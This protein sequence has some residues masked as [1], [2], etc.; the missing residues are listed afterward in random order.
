ME[1]N[2][3]NAADGFSQS[4]ENT[5][6][7]FLNM[8]RITCDVTADTIPT[9]APTRRPTRRPTQRPTP[10]PVVAP[11]RVPT[12]RPTR[13]P[14]R[15]PTPSPDDSNCVLYQDRSLEPVCLEAGNDGKYAC[16]EASDLLDARATNAC[17][18]PMPRTRILRCDGRLVS[19][20][21]SNGSQM[22]PDVFSTRSCS[23]SNCVV[24]SNYV[25]L[26]AVNQNKAYDISYVAVADPDNVTVFDMEVI[27]RADN[28]CDSAE[29]TCTDF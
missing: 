23:A 15:A 12:R 16:Y 4:S 10:R 11:T 18:Y 5:I 22:P 7:S 27:V 9:R 17:M 20:R 14:T 19:G 1:P 21:F 26:R 24:I 2:I 13:R 29:T 6:L 25:C 8:R 3:N 28:S